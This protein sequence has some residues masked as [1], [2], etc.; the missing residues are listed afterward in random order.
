MEVLK[1][2]SVKQYVKIISNNNTNYNLLNVYYA[3]HIKCQ[4][5]LI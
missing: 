5:Y 1:I 4:S 2:Y 3:K